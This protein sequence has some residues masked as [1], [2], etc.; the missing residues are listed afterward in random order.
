[1]PSWNAY[2]G[3]TSGELRK[4]RLVSAAR[5]TNGSKIVSI[6]DEA[7][8]LL[9]IDNYFEKWKILAEGDVEDTEPAQQAEAGTGRGKK[10]ANS[11]RPGKY[12]KKA[13][14]HCKYGGWNSNGIQQ[15]NA[16]RKLVEQ[17]RAC[18]QAE[19]MEKE[20]LAFCR[21]SAGGKKK[22]DDNLIRTT[23]LMV[24]GLATM[25]RKQWKPWCLLRRT[26]TQMMT[27]S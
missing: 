14:G 20:L 12:T 2:V 1:M 8:G 18:P 15:F 7:F 24:T 11:R 22:A 19:Q 21:T 16:L 13:L 23:S 10:K 5:E 9:L 26:G 3:R 6:S 27:S 4:Q 25:H 17:G